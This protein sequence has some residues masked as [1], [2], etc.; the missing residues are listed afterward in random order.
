MAASKRRTSKEL[1]GILASKGGIKADNALVDLAMSTDL[2]VT[3][4]SSG[5]L[6][7]FIRQT[8]LNKYTC[9]VYPAGDRIMLSVHG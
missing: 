5:D 1:I 9:V 3:E 7:D 4:V 2:D 6:G 8:I